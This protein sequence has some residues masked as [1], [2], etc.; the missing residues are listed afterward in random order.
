MFLQNKSQHK[1]T[2]LQ[3]R[4]LPVP[5]ADK[6]RKVYVPVMLFCNFFFK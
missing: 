1:Y 3:T 5:I 2:F 6:Y 4:D